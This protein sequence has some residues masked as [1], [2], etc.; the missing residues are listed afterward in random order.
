MGAGN[1]FRAFPAAAQQ[2]LLDKG[3]AE[4]G[5][6]VCECFDDELIGAAYTPYDNKTLLVTL[7]GNGQIEKRLIHSITEAFDGNRNPERLNEIFAGPGLQLVSFTIT[8]KGY[9]NEAIMEKVA[10]GLLARYK[11]KNPPMALVSFDN[12]SENGEVLKQAVINASLKLNEP[13]LVAYAESFSYPWSMIDKITPH[14]SPDIAALIKEEGYENIKITQTSKNTFA[15]PFVNAEACGYLVI[16]DDFPNGRLQLENA[17]IIFTD[18]LTVQKTE[19][20]KVCACLNPLHTIL[21]IG[22]ML[23]NLPTIASCMENDGLRAL[24]YKAAY[25][26]CLPIVENPG[27]I[28]PTAFLNEVL[29]ERLPNP[30]IPDTPARIATDT[31]Q[32]IPVRFGINLQTRTEYKNL[33]AIPFFFAMYLKYLRGPDD[34]G[35]PI[36]LSP[37]PRLDELRNKSIRDILSDAALFGV[38]LYAVGLGERIENIYH[39]LSSGTGALARALQLKKK[40]K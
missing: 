8:E 4:H 23:L 34:N 20:M 3:L 6:A 26:E 38:D 14:P 35:N 17:G 31:S 5:I 30:F 29:H 40:G 25:D 16:E 21:A 32:K 15:A 27:V 33:K 37:D 2:D 10:R 36:N 19:R 12:I 1:L 18:R 9:K 28:D 39:E 24:V 11:A 7:H 22:G 13:G